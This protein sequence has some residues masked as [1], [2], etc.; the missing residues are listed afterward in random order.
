MHPS[1]KITGIFLAAAVSA[2]SAVHHPS[3]GASDPLVIAKQGSFFVGG[4]EIKDKNLSLLP[5]YAPEGGGTVSVNQMYVRYQTPV[6][7]KKTPLV[8]VHGCCLT[9]KSW[10][11]T[12]DG[13]MGWD[14]LF[15]R[16]GFSTYVIDQVSRGRSASTVSDVVKV[17]AGRASAEALP[18][19]FNAAHE[20]AWELFR[21]GPEYPK[22][23]AKMNFPL[24]AQGEFWKQLVPDWYNALPVPNPTVP[25][26]SL[27]ATQLNGAI[28]ISHSQSGIYPFQVAAA[29][30]RNVK[31]IVAIEPGA[32]PSPTSDMTPY[33]GMP[34]LILWGDNTEKSPL[35]A[36]RPKQCADFVAAANRAGAKAESIMLSD[37]GM[38]GATHMLMLDKNSVEIGEWLAVWIVKNTAP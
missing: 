22:T 5:R 30:P 20:S 37:I 4:Q 11:A 1:F 27:L 18:Q 31:G 33:V 29:N 34:I 10:E 2:C 23:F 13:R 15:V 19:V 36:P 21:F 24:E 28:F 26:L 16:R 35:W 6:A 17:K 7:A 9:G 25:A 12:P 32:C 8:L 3:D 14:E 38:P